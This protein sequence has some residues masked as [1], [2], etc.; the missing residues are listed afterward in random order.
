MVPA[1]VAV[2]L[3]DRL[4]E[5]KPA[6]VTLPDLGLLI[7]PTGRRAFAG[8]PGMIRSTLARLVLLDGRYSPMFQ[9]TSDRIAFNGERVTT[10][11]I[12]WDDSAPASAAPGSAGP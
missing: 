3:S 1:L 12:G 9:K 5:I 8:T 6:G 4:A 2:A 10:W 11:R 7:D